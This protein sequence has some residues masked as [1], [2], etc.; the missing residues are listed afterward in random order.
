MGRKYKRKSERGTD[1][2]SL[3][4]AAETVTKGE[5]S[6]RK[7]AVNYGVPRTS[8]QRYLS[9]P[10]DSRCGSSYQNCKTANQVF[11]QQMEMIL[12]QHIRDM[13]H[14]YHGI[15][16]SKAR[17]LAWEFANQNQI[18]RIPPSWEANKSAG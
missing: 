14:R 3:K 11:T 12:A 13:D 9:T 16:P 18:T 10:E 7:A 17:E 5:L 1:A 15:G 6:V 4:R 2:E 8:L